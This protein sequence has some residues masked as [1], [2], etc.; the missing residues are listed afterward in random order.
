M[1]LYTDLVPLTAENFRALYTKKPLHYKGFVFHSIISGYMWKGGD[2]VKNN[3]T[4]SEFICGDTF[5]M[6]TSC[7][8]TTARGYPTAPPKTTS[9]SSLPACP[10]SM[11]TTS[12]SAV[13]SPASTTSRPSKRR[14]RSRLPT[15][16]RSSLSRRR[17]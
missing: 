6:R 1:E 7:F 15:V 9:H 11:A 8:H 16:A 3:G 2:F 10:G 17:R 12:S 13:S 14:W 5:P 4:G